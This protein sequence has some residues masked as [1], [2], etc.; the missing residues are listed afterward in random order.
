MV[1]S[2]NG[3]RYSRAAQK[4]HLRS[5]CIGHRLAFFAR[6]IVSPSTPR[7]FIWS[8]G[9]Q[10]SWDLWTCW[11]RHHGGW[12]GMNRMNSDRQRPLGEWCKQLIRPATNYW[13]AWIETHESWCR[14]LGHP[15]RNCADFAIKKMMKHLTLIEYGCELFASWLVGVCQNF[16]W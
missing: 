1:I 10:T 2:T 14:S 12:W 4:G 6:H 5:T 9:S 15:R 7:A 3:S 11:W 13:I 8:S 16:I